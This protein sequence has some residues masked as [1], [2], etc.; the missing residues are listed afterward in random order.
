MSV[1]FKKKLSSLFGLTAIGSVMVASTN[2]TSDLV[3][4]KTE[5]KPVAEPNSQFGNDSE[6]EK[7]KGGSST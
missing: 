2:I 4:A 3:L 1:K 7:P 6:Q 5:V